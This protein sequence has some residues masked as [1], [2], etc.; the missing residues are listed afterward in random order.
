M[1][2]T[3]RPV[4]V[5]H[6]REPLGIGEAAPR[7]SWV[8]DT[9][10]PGWAQQAYE[11]EVSDPARPGAPAWTTGRVGSRDQVLVDWPAAPLTSRESRAV[12]VRVWGTDEAPTPWSEPTV[13]E[14]GLLDPAAW[15]ARMV[16]PCCRRWA[17]AVNP[18]C[19]CAARC[20]CAATW[21]GPGCAPPRTAS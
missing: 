19:C 1:H 2:P 3:V 14:T 5:E 8:T 17:R 7:L 9:D 16:C 12:R 18:R 4:T 20:T 13:L 11:I 10:L 21:C 6:H 15:R